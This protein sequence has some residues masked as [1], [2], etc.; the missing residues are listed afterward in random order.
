MCACVRV[1]EEEEEGAAAKQV[2]ADAIRKKLCRMCMR[3]CAHV[4]VFACATSTRLL[5]I[6]V[7]KLLFTIFLLSLAI[8]LSLSF[9]LP[10]LL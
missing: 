5:I 2:D 7:L 4:R 6:R 1:I 3:A 8:F 9:Y 10:T